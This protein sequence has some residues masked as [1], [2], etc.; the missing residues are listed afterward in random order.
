MP[1]VG[2]LSCDC[3]QSVGFWMIDAGSS[4]HVFYTYLLSQHK[5]SPLNHSHHCYPHWSHCPHCHQC[6]HYCFRRSFQKFGRLASLFFDLTFR[7]E[8]WHRIENTNWKR[9]H[10]SKNNNFSEVCL[11][12]I[13][14]A[15]VWF[16]QMQ[17]LVRCFCCSTV[18]SRNCRLCFQQ[19][20]LCKET[21]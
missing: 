11:H 5:L 6:Q 2:S 10:R 19:M 4:W 7:W 15:C 20:K 9:L 8:V 1:V 12:A 16:W 3:A 17:F 14:F 18:W 13:F 21:F